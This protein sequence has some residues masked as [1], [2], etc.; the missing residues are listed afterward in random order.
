L[1]EYSA[2]A[3]T[4]S[5]MMN[6]QARILII[7][8]DAKTV[9]TIERYLTSAGFQTLIA[10][11]GEAGDKIA[12]SEP[13]DLIV[14]DL[15][16]PRVDGLEVCRRVRARGN[17]PII[18]LTARA[19]EE[20]RIA[21]LSRGADDYVIK[22]FSPRELVAR[23]HAVLRRA[24]AR[25]RSPMSSCFGALELDL[26]GCTVSIAGRDAELTRTEYD[27]L[28]ALCSTPGI[29]WRR[30]SLIERV[31]GW[32]YDGTARTIDTHVSNLRKKL[33]KTGLPLNTKIET[34]FGMGY[35][36]THCDDA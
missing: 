8:D 29:A 19:D 16:L 32:D 15:M 1:R 24:E 3:A 20:E 12:A 30:D 6:A 28:L 18:V 9:A 33:E 23:V 13:V 22:P 4:N 10:R 2:V 17:T 35:R 14:L 27:I 31:L 26:H 36:F 11:D 34:V 7:E 21:G 25:V 5:S